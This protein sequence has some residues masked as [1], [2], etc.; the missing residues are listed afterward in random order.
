VRFPRATRLFT[1]YK[2]DCPFVPMVDTKVVST[3]VTVRNG[4]SVL[5]NSLETSRKGFAL[6]IGSQAFSK[7]N[8][9]FPVNVSTD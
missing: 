7:K 9:A 2:A 5:V 8:V 4:A 3:P 6:T 1:L